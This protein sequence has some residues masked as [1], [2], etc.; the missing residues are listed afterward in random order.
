LVRAD[1]VIEFERKTITFARYRGQIF[2][3]GTKVQ[4]PLTQFPTIVAL[5]EKFDHQKF[6]NDREFLHWAHKLRG[7]RTYTFDEVIGTVS[8]YLLV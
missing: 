6:D 3:D 8:L 7:V 5:N 2:I 1:D 4:H